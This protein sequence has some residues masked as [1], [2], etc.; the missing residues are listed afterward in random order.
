[1]TG[2][3][4]AARSAVGSVA[5]KT[6]EPP[7]PVARRRGATSEDRHVRQQALGFSPDRRSPHPCQTSA[8]KAPVLRYVTMCRFAGFRTAICL[9]LAGAAGCVAVPP[10]QTVE[11]S[12]GRLLG[13]WTLARVGSRGVS[14]AMTLGFKRDSVMIGTLRCNSMSGHY[15]VRPP[16]IV[17]PD[18]VI[19]T[20]AGCS[21]WA[22][23]RPVV[24]IAERVLFRHPPPASLLSA[25]GDRLFVRG[26]QTLQFIRTR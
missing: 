10:P 5:A 26:E 7:P 1:M 20:T 16:A 4:G 8:R 22:S 23:N 25:S 13:E 21:N 6:D 3:S 19:I 12:E 9:F 24:D 11:I 17:F 15:Q 18:S 2:P 14:R